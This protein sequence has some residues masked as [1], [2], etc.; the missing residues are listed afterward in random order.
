MDEII[1]DF[2]GDGYGGD[3]GDGYGFGDYADDSND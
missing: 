2:C 1:F 3:S